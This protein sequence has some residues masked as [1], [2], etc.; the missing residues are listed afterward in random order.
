MNHRLRS[1]SQK[2]QN[3]EDIYLSFSADKCQIYDG[4]ELGKLTDNLIVPTSNIGEDGKIFSGKGYNLAI[5]P[6]SKS[7]RHDSKFPDGPRGILTGKPRRRTTVP[8]DTKYSSY[9]SNPNKFGGSSAVINN[10]SP[11]ST[12]NSLSSTKPPMRR[13]KSVPNH[14]DME[15]NFCLSGIMKAPKYSSQAP[16]ASHRRFS[17]SKYNDLV[18]VFHRFNLDEELGHVPFQGLSRTQFSRSDLTNARSMS[19]DQEDVISSSSHHSRGLAQG[20]SGKQSAGSSL[21]STSSVRIDEDWLPKGVEFSDT[22]EV[23]LYMK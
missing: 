14:R 10:I 21:T 13:R 4:R 20:K 3:Q 19:V 6:S 15:T 23:Y 17:I 11:A 16:N 5:D 18:D 12:T 2:L 7:K 8:S 22:A 1:T 9:T